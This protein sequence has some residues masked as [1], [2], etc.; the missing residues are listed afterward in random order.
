MSS[1]TCPPH[2]WWIESA[3]KSDIGEE[4]WT[5]RLCGM[6]KL[7]HRVESRAKTGELGLSNVSTVTREDLLVAGWD[8]I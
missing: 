7:P 2:H 4:R 3:N 5:C 1:G 8:E 6:V